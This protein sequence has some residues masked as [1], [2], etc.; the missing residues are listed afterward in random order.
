MMRT[1]T[2]SALPTRPL[3]LTQLVLQHSPTAR[4]DFCALCGRPTTAPA[5]T[6]L[7]LPNS[8]LACKDCGRKHAPSLAALVH[9]AA[10]AERIARIGRHTV[11]PPLTALLELARA[12]DAYHYSA[13]H[14]E[15]P[16]AN[17]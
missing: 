9:L 14:L 2:A 7:C 3:A 13:T 15:R 16:T 6:Q 17:R 8:E 5:G 12:A 10:E 1:P 4:E 11:F